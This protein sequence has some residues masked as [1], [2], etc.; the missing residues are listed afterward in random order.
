M[1]QIWKGVELVN[2][3]PP[4]YTQRKGPFERLPQGKYQGSLVEDIIRRDP[5]Y[6][7]WAVKEWLDVS[8]KQA[9][10]FTLL[11]DGEIPLRYISEDAPQDRRNVSPYN[12]GG[13]SQADEHVYW[14]NQDLIP[15][16]DFDPESA[17]TWWE[18]YKRKVKGETHPAKRL[19]VYE[20]FWKRDFLKMRDSLI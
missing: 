8:P 17:P 9:T 18:E 5:R 7:M 10:L 15:N 20:Q 12:V 16:Y 11:T 2:C 14:T 6:F 1:G 13:W 3:S 4:T 19:A